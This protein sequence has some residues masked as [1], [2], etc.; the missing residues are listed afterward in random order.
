MVTSQYS[1]G[2]LFRRCIGLKVHYSKGALV[3]KLVELLLE[4]KLFIQTPPLPL[5]FV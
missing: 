1:K 4:L 5:R 3:R 2:S